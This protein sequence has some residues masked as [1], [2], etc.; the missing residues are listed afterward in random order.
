MNQLAKE[1]EKGRIGERE[2]KILILINFVVSCM[3]SN[4]LKLTIFL[5]IS[6][7]AAAQTFTSSNLP[8]IIINTDNNVPVPDNPRVKATMKIIYR[9]PGV[10]NYLTDQNTAAC[11]NYNGRINIEIRGSSSQYSLKK[12]YGFSTKLSDGATNNNVKLLGMPSEHD[13]ILNSMVFD[14][15]LVRDYMC[16]NLS[17]RIGEYASRTA[18]CE[19]MLNGSYRGLYLLEE[20]I[21]AD[22]NR[23]DVFKITINDNYSPEVTGGYIIKADKTTG[24]DPVAW[25]MPAW[26]G[27]QV[28]FLNDFPD[29]E[30]VTELQTAYIKH[31]FDLLQDAA[32]T[33]N[34]SITTGY[35]SIIDIPS[36]I[37][38][39]II[40]ELS[41][42]CD[43]YQYST[44]YHKDRNGKLRSGPVWD[45]DLTFGNDL[46]LWQLDRSWPNVWQFSNGDNEGPRF[47]R[48][49]FTD[50][51]FKCYL[52]K[53]WNELIQPG[54]PLNINRLKNFIDSTVVLISEA[55]AR[56]NTTWNNVR[57]LQKRIEQIKT[58]LDQRIPWITSNLPSPSGCSNVS[59]PHLV[60]T[61]IMYHPDTTINFPDNDDREFIEITN[62]GDQSAD[63]TGVYF[64]STG[65][66][67][68]F[69]AG[70]SINAHASVVLASS[71]SGFFSTYKT[72]P[73]GQFTRHLSNKSEKLVLADA[74][75][76][77]IDSVTYHDSPPWPS[78]DGNG[79]H[80]K[81]NDP[82]SDNSI[83]QNWTA[84]NELLISGD[85]T[86]LETKVS[87]YPNP[88]SDFLQIHAGYEMESVTLLDLS[89][90]VIISNDRVDSPEYYIDMRKYDPGI[91]L[92]KI[93]MAAGAITYKIVKV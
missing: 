86:P 20:K 63:L 75:G 17:R 60:I 72:A 40:S 71:Y 79:Y 90:R 58:W 51:I 12:Q 50:N 19:L 93:K 5:F 56:D 87:V 9:G 18:Y 11:L 36:F 38:Y 25:R 57:N 37:D 14:S 64:S 80:L 3:R 70:S 8:I 84:S 83:A 10:R 49:L 34:A 81:L 4:L 23:V 45:S 89:G 67:Y 88:V 33:G 2:K 54:Q 26:N 28:D 66:V 61:R 22:D 92:V 24:G 27:S 73:F 35:P 48:D 46:F 52:S 68:Q 15:A 91:Y 55:A 47:W 43:S 1:E 74:F 41:S 69:P 42:N 65:L 30:T 82:L 13:W 53:R 29:P 76:N 32:L 21:K 6:I 78:A 44:Y 7:P 85:N 77:V 31:Q 39:M 62:A 16:F 59:L